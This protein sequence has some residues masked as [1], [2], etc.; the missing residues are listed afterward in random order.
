MELG[1]T[2]IYVT[3]DQVEAMTM[4]DRIAVIKDGKLQAYAIHDA[5]VSRTTNGTGRV[6]DMSLEQIKRLDAGQGER[7]PILSEVIEL[8]HGCVR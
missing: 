4:A 2:S 6:T 8:A 3:H 5:Q 1:I 7:V